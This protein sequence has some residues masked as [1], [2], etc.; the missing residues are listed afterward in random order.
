MLCDLYPCFVK[1]MMSLYKVWVG[2]SKWDRII[3]GCGRKNI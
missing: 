3:L 2:E 1:Q